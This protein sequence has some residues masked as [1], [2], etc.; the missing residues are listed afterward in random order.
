MATTS[1]VSAW[2]LTEPGLQVNWRFTIFAAVPPPQICLD[3]GD[4]LRAL[5]RLSAF[6]SA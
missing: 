3:P 2:G 5:R 6:L 4:V 1:Q